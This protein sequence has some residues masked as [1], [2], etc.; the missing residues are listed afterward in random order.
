MGMRGGGLDKATRQ[1][2]ILDRHSDNVFVSAQVDRFERRP[3][4]AGR[5]TL[6]KMGR[7]SD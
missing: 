5:I 7:R 6:N 1:S 4:L 2:G 3:A